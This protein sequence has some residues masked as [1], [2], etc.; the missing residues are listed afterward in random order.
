MERRAEFR[1]FS[2]INDL[3]RRNQLELDPPYQRRSVW[4]DRYKS[5]FITTALLNYPCPAI[6]LFEEIKPDGR[7]FYKLVDG[8]QRITTL[9]DFVDG[10]MAV[11][12]SYPVPQLRGKFFN[13]FED[14]TKLKI[15]RYSFAVEFIDQENEAII[16]DI[17]NRINKNV[18]RLTHQELRNARFYGLFA[19]QV[20]RLTIYL[21]QKLPSGFPRIAPQ[22]KRQMKDVE[23]VANLLLFCEQ[24]EKSVSQIDLDE[25]YSKRE[26][27]WE[28]EIQTSSE[29]TAVIDYISKI[30]SSD[31]EAI[32][33]SRLRNQADFYS[34]FGA[35]FEL[36]VGENEPSP[37][38]AR[39]KLKCWLL[40]LSAVDKSGEGDEDDLAY[41]TAARSASNDPTPRRTRINRIKAVLRG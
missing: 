10:H 26:D 29:F 9:L 35:I 2:W 25:A 7:F 12:E 23:N 18:A 19:K 3:Y 14:S 16:D 5:E 11:G 36:I 22:S 28:K 37:E 33:N 20:D 6:F 1:Y 32:F 21:D 8:K 13:D 4:S 34:L 39:A 30:M 27:E 17:F 41:L 15:W 31:S 24:G 38:E 40:Q